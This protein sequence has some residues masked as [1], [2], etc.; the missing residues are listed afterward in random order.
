MQITALKILIVC[1]NKIAYI[2]ISPITALS[3]E[4]RKKHATNF[5]KLLKKS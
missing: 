2:D 5:K 1:Q 4:I 3:Q